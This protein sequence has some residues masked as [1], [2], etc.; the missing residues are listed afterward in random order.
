MIQEISIDQRKTLIPLFDEH[1][2]L[3]SI[4]KSILN[5]GWGKVYVENPENPKVALISYT[6]F[7]VLTGN[8]KSEV[9]RDLL[10]HIPHHKIILIPNDDWVDL[11]REYW[12]IRLVEKKND[13]TKFSSSELDLR[14]IKMFKEKLPEGFTIEHINPKNA[15]IF[16][17]TMKETFF[18]LF[19]SIEVFLEKGFG[20]CIKKGNE[21]IGAAATG[22]PLYNNTFEIQVYIQKKYRRRG[23][24]TVICAYLI[25]YSLE[26]GIEPC[27]DA[28]NKNSAKLALKLGYT[29]PEP[30]S[31]YFHT[32]LPIIILRKLKIN[33][34]IFYALKFLGK[35]DE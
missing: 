15:Q 24:A 29:D 27:W 12:G 20:F 3:T 1:P 30:Y 6:S 22:N 18:F 32:K 8:S 11:L 2:Y 28:E 21:I 26:N 5:E 16:D 23:L 25:E 10:S 17:K 9:A 33:R 31:Y 35:I 4:I 14:Q 34:L 13:R 19:G 7:Y